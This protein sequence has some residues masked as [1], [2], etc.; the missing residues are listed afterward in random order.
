KTDLKIINII[1]Q[2][3][4][5]PA[6]GF[7]DIHKFCKKNKLKIPK[8]ETLIKKIK[9]KKYKASQTHFLLTGIRTDMPEKGLKKIIQ[10]LF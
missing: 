1:K 5:I 2:E 6:I 3:S 4:K 10:L 9:T 7:I 8:T